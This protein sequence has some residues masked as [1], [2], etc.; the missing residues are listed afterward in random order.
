MSQH[1]PCEHTHRCVRWPSSLPQPLEPRTQ[2]QLWRGT[3]QISISRAVLLSTLSIK[4]LL[5]IPGVSTAPPHLPVRW[6][7]AGSISSEH[8]VQISVRH[9]VW[10]CWARSWIQF[11]AQP[12]RL[13]TTTVSP[14][15]NDC[16]Y[17]ANRTNFSAPIAVRASGL[18]VT[19]PADGHLEISFDCNDKNMQLL[20]P[21][22][23]SRWST[24]IQPLHRY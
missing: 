10:Q 5:L 9:W 20:L 16:P 3:R 13:R 21:L 8:R 17:D 12:R 1:E 19:V 23:V 7:Q 22:R 4:Q 15:L 14:H 24:S 11:H 2:T 6:L 18:S